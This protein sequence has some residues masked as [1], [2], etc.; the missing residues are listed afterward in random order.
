MSNR[1]SYPFYQGIWRKL[2]KN[3]YQ[4]IRS[5]GATSIIARSFAIGLLVEFVTLPTLGLA[6]LLLYP[7]IR[8]FK[9]VFSVALIGFLMGK[10]ILPIFLYLNF[11]VGEFLI[12]KKVGKV[13]SHE[14]HSYFSLTFIKERGLTF[15]L[16]SFI[17][18]VIVAS[19]SYFLVYYGLAA[20]RKAKEKRIQARQEQ[21]AKA[22]LGVE[23]L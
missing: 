7:L 16:G 2:K 12:G 1:K 8:L 10:L 4:L 14:I 9:G 3:Y 15:L 21:R 22:T 17:N 18:G 20:Y 23:E 13:L 11:H 5:K 19:I 6:F